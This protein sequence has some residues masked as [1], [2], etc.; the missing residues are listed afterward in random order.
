MATALSLERPSLPAISPAQRSAAKVAGFLYLLT[1]A[2]AMFGEMFVR[3][4]LVV[5]GDALETARN[6][7]E[8]ELLF[9]LSI[10]TDLLTITG[11]IVLVWA[12]YVVLR[13][14]QESLSLLAAFFRLTENAIGAVATLS[15]FA[16]L[17]YLSGAS[18]LRALSAE[19]LA[20]L[21]ATVR[22]GQGAG[23]GVSFVFLGIGSALSGWLWLRSRYVP[24]GFA[25]LGIFASSLL[26]LGT[27]AV[28]VLPRLGEAVG[29]TY[30]VPMFFYEVGLGIWLLAKGLRDPGAA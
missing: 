22:R 3:G 11:V 29:L 25:I 23:L 6:L 18:P 20:E 16:A 1:M 10:A 28:F 15:S 24:R 12:L 9:R 8:S 13:P 21:A 19:Q 7:Q 5:V 30:M 27:L 14:V 4:R 17:S 2:T 26:S